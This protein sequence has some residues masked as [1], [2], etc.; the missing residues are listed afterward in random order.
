M[1]MTAKQ[2]EKLLNAALRDPDLTDRELMVLVS[3][4]LHGQDRPLQSEMAA[5]MGRSTRYIK[6]GVAGLREKGWLAVTRTQSGNVY[7][8]A[9]P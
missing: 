1:Q 6:R 2:K 5:R 7:R 3:I 4:I 9:A 8:V